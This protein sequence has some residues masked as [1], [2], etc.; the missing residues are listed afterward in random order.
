MLNIGVLCSRRAP[1]LDVLL[2][3]GRADVSSA[4]VGRTGRPPSFEIGCVIATHPG[5]PY[6]TRPVFSPRREYDAGTRDLLR[7][8]GTDLVLLLGYTYIVTDTLLYEYPILNIH[9]SDLRITRPDGERRYTGLHS[10][11]DAILAGEK[12]TRSTLHV[13]TDKL[14]GGPIISVSRAY[15]VAPFV[16]DAA[17]AGYMD[18]VRAY[19]YAQR[20]WMMRDSWGEMLVAALSN[21]GRTSRPPNVGGRDVRP[22]HAEAA[23]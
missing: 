7:A 13:V 12:E 4:A 23:A 6:L 8:A 21:G 9:D 11:R 3:H 10:T 2:A 16:H 20:E 22:P 15:P 17:K 5:T 1:G 19:A 18:I 14:D